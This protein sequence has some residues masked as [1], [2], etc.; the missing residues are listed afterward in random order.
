M[1]R[2]MEYFLLLIFLFFAIGYN[3]AKIDSLTL[4]I[5]FFIIL[6]C[7]MLIH[8]YFMDKKN[9]KKSG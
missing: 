3:I 9:R 6:T 2:Q 8:I 1:F 4:S 5:T 7:L